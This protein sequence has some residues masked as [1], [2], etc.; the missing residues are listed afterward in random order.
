MNVGALQ[1]SVGTDQ[2]AAIARF[3]VLGTQVCAVN[4]ESARSAICDWIEHGRRCHYICVTGVHGVMEGLRNPEICRAH[5]CAD[6]VVPD[7]M[8]LVF[9]AKLHLHNETRRVYGPD[10][11]T[12][13]LSISPGKGY[14]NFFYGGKPG[15]ADDLATLMRTLYPGLPVSG[16]ISPPFGD[17]PNS[18]EERFIDAINSSNTHILWIGLSTPRQEL[19]MSRWHDRLNCSVMIGVGAAFDFLSGRKI[20][21]PRW[22]MHIGMEWFFRMCSEPRRLAPRYLRNNPAFVWHTFLQLT[23]LRKYPID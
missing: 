10:L 13:L 5:N 14:R 9:L 16:V 23:H 22:M 8:P 12:S 18:D 2:I 15:V 3:N 1:M 11:M 7:G 20:Q 4:P 19:L 6:M 17:L 21:A